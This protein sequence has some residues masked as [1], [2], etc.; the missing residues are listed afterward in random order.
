MLICWSLVIE[1]ESLMEQS[2]KRI[3]MPATWFVLCLLMAMSSLADTGVDA[4]PVMASAAWLRSTV[5][6]Q[7]T[8]AAYVELTAREPLRLLGARSPLAARAEL[9]QM[10]MAGGVMKMTPLPFL[11]LHPG[12]T[13]ALRPG[14]Y[15]LMLYGLQQPL[16]AGDWL[17]LQLQFETRSKRRF[18]LDVRAQVRGVSGASEVRAESASHGHGMHGMHH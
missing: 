7:Q 1:S 6:G 16:A 5:A 12:K 8:S 11:E 18:T 17:P 4:P 2:Q 3:F 14:S 13:L 10:V 9:H 15:H